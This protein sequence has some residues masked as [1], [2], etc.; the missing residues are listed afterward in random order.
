MVQ[1]CM[2]EH[3][4]TYHVPSTDRGKRGRTSPVL[5]KKNGYTEQVAVGRVINEGTRTDHHRDASPKGEDDIRSRPAG[6]N[7]R[8]LAVS[9]PLALERG[10]FRHGRGAANCPGGGSAEQ[11]NLLFQNRLVKLDSAPRAPLHCTPWVGP[12]NTV[13]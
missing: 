4:R 13:V 12:L 3:S 5:Q 11:V 10:E 6:V 8:R 1:I 7:L 2:H 9:S